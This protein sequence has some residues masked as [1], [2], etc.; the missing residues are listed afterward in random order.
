MQTI[1]QF[2]KL[3]SAPWAAYHDHPDADTAS[4]LA[5]IRPVGEKMH[6]DDVAMVSLCDYPGDVGHVQRAR[7]DLI[8]A[9][10]ELLSALHQ[11][12]LV[13]DGSHPLPHMAIDMARSVIA[14]A[15]GKSE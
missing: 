9:A 7:R 15:T 1:K 4:S 13:A 3:V 6:G 2:L 12:L 5:Y 11:L 14:K 10:P 8:A